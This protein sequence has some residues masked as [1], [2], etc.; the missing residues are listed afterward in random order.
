MRMLS[1]FKYLYVIAIVIALGLFVIDHGRA[2]TGSGPE[3]EPLYPNTNAKDMDADMPWRVQDADTPIPVIWIIKDSDQW[4][5][6]V[7]EMK[8]V[9]LY[10]VTD[11]YTPPGD[12]DNPISN[13]VVY[14]HDF[15]D[16]EISQDYWYWLTTTFEN[17][18]SYKGT[19]PNGTPFTPANLGYTEGDTICFT[20]RLYG[21]DGIWPFYTD[22]TL[23]QDFKVHVGEAPLPTLDD[24]YWGDV[25]NHGWKTDNL[26][27]FADP[28]DA[29]AL[30]AEAIGISF[31]TITDHASDLSTSKWNALGNECTL[32]STPTLRLLRGQ[33]MH[34]NQGGLANVRHMLGYGL[35]T[36]VEGDEDGTYSITEILGGPTP[37][38]HV[39]AQNAF[40]YAAHPTDPSLGWSF[41]EVESALAFDCFVGL[42]FF[43]E[44]NSHFSEMD[45]TDD[46]DEYH[47]W[48]GDDSISPHNRDWTYTNTTWDN[49][50][51]AGFPA[52]DLLLS[53]RLDPVRKVFL[54]GGADAHGAWNYRVYRTENLVDLSA[55]PSAMGKVRTAIYLPDGLNDAGILDGLKTGRSIVTDGP[56]MVFGI[57]GNKDGA[58]YGPK[59][60]IIGDGPV[61]VA[62]KDIRSRFHFLW[63]SSTEFGDVVCIRLYKGTAGT[64][65]NPQLIWEHYPNSYTGDVAGPLVSE[66]MGA[67]GEIVYYRAEAYTYDP[68]GP[69]PPPGEVSNYSYDA[70]NNDYNY[71]CFTNPIWVKAVLP[72]PRM[73]PK[74]AVPLIR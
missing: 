17:D 36:Y 51:M 11:G 69:T 42:Q 21:K 73:K 22:V 49:D 63:N 26:Y 55:T 39:T 5:A 45:W 29:K 4:L 62:V 43:N 67:L 27:E 72:G 60:A 28:T 37:S 12:F 32:Y 13:H 3:D 50:L 74:M 18:G 59:D 9:V 35:S 40:A 48:G 14:Y 33:E 20:L 46:D 1:I 8:Y 56:A 2:Q 23:D 57:D 64:Q 34:A 30:A 41:Q 65:E 68:A 66:N 16:Q 47:P 54:S 71:R 52:W 10:D 15:N 19:Q 58:L 53:D 38:N 61:H 31:V 24:W 6:E 70:V 44:R 7:D 25:H